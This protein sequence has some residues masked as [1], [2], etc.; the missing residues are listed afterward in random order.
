LSYL[1][2]GL[3]NIALKQ[4]LLFI[5][6]ACLILIGFTDKIEL[7]ESGDPAGKYG[8]C[9]AD[10]SQP[11]VLS[12]ELTLNADHTFTY[13]NNMDSEEKINVSGTWSLYEGEIFLANYSSEVKILKIWKPEKNYT[14]LKS[15]KGTAYYRLCRIGEVV[16]R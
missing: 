7:N 8:I 2:D 11:H 1:R 5:L 9:M 4:I 15:R 3:K 13:V 10:E 16:S 12:V 6:P 14:A